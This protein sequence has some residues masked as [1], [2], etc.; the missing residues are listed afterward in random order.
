[1]GSDGEEARRQSRRSWPIEVRELADADRSDL[2]RTT[3]AEERLAMMW[4]LALEA[5]RLAGRP[6]P[7][8]DRSEIPARV[9]RGYLSR[10]AESRETGDS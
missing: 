5:W 3:T 1:M 4:P 10:D 9:I 2:F 8:Y 7:D 6:I